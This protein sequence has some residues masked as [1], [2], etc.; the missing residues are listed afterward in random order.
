MYELLNIFEIFLPQL[1]AY[2]N[3]ADPLNGEA[4]S[5]HTRSPAAYETKVRD[6]VKKF[7]SGTVDVNE[8]LNSAVATTANKK[9]KQS[10]DLS[11]SIHSQ[12]T[13][14]STTSLEDSDAMSSVG[15]LSDDEEVVGSIE[16]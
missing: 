1:L 3:S 4:A 12:H 2:P 13:V 11:D 8:D 16:I 5:L 7:A 9:L 14:A 15:V 10:T 6:W